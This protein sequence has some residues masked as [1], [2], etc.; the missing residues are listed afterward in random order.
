MSDDTRYWTDYPFTQLGDVAHT[1][2]PIREVQ[3]LS[4]DGDKYVRIRLPDGSTDE[5]KSGYLYTAEG[6]I[7]TV[8][9][10]SRQALQA[11]K[12]SPEPPGDM[13]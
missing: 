4:Y 3:A 6:R 13:E 9:R 5:I 7:G 2:A 10:I 8:P 11:L 12:P 1:E